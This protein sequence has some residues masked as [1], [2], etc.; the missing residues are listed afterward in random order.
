MHAKHI[1]LCALTF[2]TAVAASLRAETKLSMDGAVQAALMGN[3]ELA[4]ARYAVNIAKGRLLQAGLLPNPDFEF[5]GMSD[6]AF[7]AQGEGAFTLGLSQRFPLTARLSAERQVRRVEVAQALREIRDQER[8]LIAQVQALYVRIQAA[9]MRE[10][11]SAAARQ[12]T[13][14]LTTLAAQRLTVGQGSLA[15]SG[16][17]RVEERRWA[18]ASAVAR[19]EAESLLLE[20]KTAV[21][22]SADAPLLL[23]ESLETI[24]SR[25]RRNAPRSGSIHRP[26]ADIALLEID[27]AGAEVRLAKAGA[28][29]GIR[30]GVEYTYDHAVD[31]PDGLGTNQF[32]GLRVSIPL[33]VWDQN[34]GAI[35]GRR[36]AQEQAAAKVRA[37]ELEIANTIATAARRAALFGEQ[38][39]NYQSSTESVVA[40]SEQELAKGFEQGRVD[41]R[42]LLQVQ[43]QSATLRVEAVTLR[44]NLALALVAWQAAAGSHPAVS[45]PYTETRTLGEKSSAKRKQP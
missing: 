33:P 11:S 15:E 12:S 6:F 27:R 26:D 19:T 37:I 32:L 1:L 10:K 29:E 16:L 25:L 17:A 22:L 9:R 38:L 4:A 39:E 36:A 30:L 44:E 7:G 42:D 31:E 14:D 24:V 23:S 40:T 2:A 35:A 41:L 8:L 45:Q 13:V 3:R 18:N 34:K 28:W 5:S 21:G 20:L 43:A